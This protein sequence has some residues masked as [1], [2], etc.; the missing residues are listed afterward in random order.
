MRCAARDGEDVAFVQGQPGCAV[1]GWGELFAGLGGARVLQRSA[2]LV[3]GAAVDDLKDVVAPSC[4]SNSAA[5]L[6]ISVVITM[7]QVNPAE[8]RRPGC[9][10]PLGR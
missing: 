2:D 1:G 4:C 7:A 6:A 3:G 5:L 10:C 8:A 9:C